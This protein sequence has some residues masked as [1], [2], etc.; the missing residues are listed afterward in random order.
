LSAAVPVNGADAG[1]VGGAATYMQ[2]AQISAAVMEFMQWFI[3]ITKEMAGANE[4]VLGESAPTN[5]SAI[6]VNS[7]NAAVPLNSIKRRFYRYI[8][9]VGLI[10]LDF[11]STHYTEYP[12]RNLEVT[13]DNVKQVIPFDMSILQSMKLK[14]KIDVGPSTQWSEAAAAQTLDNLLNLEKISF[15]EYLRRLPNGLIPNKQGLIDDRESEEAKKAQEEKEFLYELMAKEMER[16]EPTLPP[17]ER[18]NLKMLQRNDPGGYETQIRQL[19]KQP[20]PYGN[21]VNQQ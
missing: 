19:I 16:I 2:P 12:A 15:I 20:R 3:N 17:E 5:T 9:D 6:I 14:L 8:E 11:W 10:W 21:N 18:S 4:A 7:K 13:K 1:G